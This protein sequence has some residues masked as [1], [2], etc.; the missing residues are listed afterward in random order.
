[1]DIVDGV[2]MQMVMP[3]LGGPPQDTALGRAL[4]QRGEHELGDAARCVGAVRKVSMVAGPD[5]EDPQPVKRDADRNCLPCDPAPDGADAGQMH[6]YERYGGWIDDVVM[7]AVR[8]AR[9]IRLLVGHWTGPHSRTRIALTIL[10]GE[11]I[12]A[13]QDSSPD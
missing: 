4:R 13:F 3:V 10:M 6:E 11:Q 2:G 12:G 9:G 7:L 8:L 5:G 1:M